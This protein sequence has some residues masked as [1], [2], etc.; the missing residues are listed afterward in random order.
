MVNWKHKLG[1]AAV[2]FLLCAAVLL[3]GEAFCRLFLDINFRRTS[4]DFVVT[5]TAGTVVANAKN[6]RG[7]SFGTEV[8][9]DENGFR[10][11]PNRRKRR[12]N[13]LFCSSAIR[14]LSE[15]VFP[16]KKLCRNVQTAKSEFDG[17]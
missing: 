6:G 3:A 7:V 16:K 13:G 15:S 11:N 8:F 10:I 12:T 2:S 9:S 14:L 1:A 17:L 5:N 4:R